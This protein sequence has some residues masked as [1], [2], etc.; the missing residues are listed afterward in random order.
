MKRG[1]W[2]VLLFGAGYVAAFAGMAVTLWRTRVAST[3]S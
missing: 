2:K 1:I 3:E